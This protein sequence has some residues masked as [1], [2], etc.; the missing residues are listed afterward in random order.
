[1]REDTARDQ[2]ERVCERGAE[3]TEKKQASIKESIRSAEPYETP[4]KTRTHGKPRR[5]EQH[6][7]AV[8]LIRRA[9]RDAALV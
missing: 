1:M 6:E 7:N 3:R 9:D 5:V 4:V 2:R 8:T